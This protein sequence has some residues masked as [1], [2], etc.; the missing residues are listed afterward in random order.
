MVY[1][2]LAQGFE[3]SEAILPLDILR[4][5]EI[6]VKTVGVGGKLITGGHG[7]TVTADVTDSEVEEGPDVECVILPGGNIGTLN[8][9]KSRKVADFVDYALRNGR[10]VAA[11]CAAPTVLGDNGYLAGRSATCYPG[12]EKRLKGANY[13]ELPVVS[14]RNIITGWGPGA[15]MEFG[16][17]ILEYLRGREVAKKVG[18]SMLCVL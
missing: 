13:V 15:S 14:D 10:L 17:E 7:I 9:S 2:F 4:R 3:E 6:P 8:L 12:L 5:A 11:I 18:D 16:F 1:L